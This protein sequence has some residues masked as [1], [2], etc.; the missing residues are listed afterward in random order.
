MIL[1]VFVTTPMGFAPVPG[2]NDAN[3]K[4]IL[5][6]TLRWTLEDVVLSKQRFP[7]S[8]TPVALIWND[9]VDDIRFSVPHVAEDDRNSNVALAEFVFERIKFHLSKLGIQVHG[10]S[11]KKGDDKHVAPCSIFPFLGFL[12]DTVGLWV[13][14]SPAKIEKAD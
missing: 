11:G 6:I 2:I 3:V 7:L 1:G 12:V 8:E 13:I 9:F 14:I 5:R 10:P 4:E